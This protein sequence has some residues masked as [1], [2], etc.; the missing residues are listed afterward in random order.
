MKVLIPIVIGLVVVGCDES[1]EKT[2]QT[3]TTLALFFTS[4]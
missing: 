1:T 2:K 3:D 4:I